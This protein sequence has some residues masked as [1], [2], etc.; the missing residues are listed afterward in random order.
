MRKLVLVTLA[1]L[2]VPAMA[3]TAAGDPPHPSAARWDIQTVA[4][5]RYLRATASN[6]EGPGKLMFLC[7]ERRELVVMAMLA[8]DDADAVAG[9][10]R[11]AA[12]VIDTVFL[13]DTASAGSQPVVMNQAVMSL[14]GLDGTVYRRIRAAGSAGI[15]WRDEGGAIRAGFQIGMAEGREPLAA[16]ARECNAQAYP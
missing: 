9:A 4:G 10:A 6:G 11:S 1:A 7:N 12:W 16:F 14:I 8:H 15:V 5:A 3:Q 13:A 2:A